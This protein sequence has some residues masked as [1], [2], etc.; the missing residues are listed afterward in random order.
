VVRPFADNEITNLIDT[1][2][3]PLPLR[4]DLR[5]EGGVTIAWDVDLDRTDLGQH[6]LGAVPV[7]EFPPSRPAATCLM[8]L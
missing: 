4:D 8:P 2:E 3:A 1:R 5:L 7:G 6:G